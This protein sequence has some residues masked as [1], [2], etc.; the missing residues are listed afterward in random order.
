VLETWQ[1]TARFLIASQ[2]NE[3]HLAFF[4]ILMYYFQNGWVLPIFSFHITYL[5]EYR[6]PASQPAV[7]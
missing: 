2:T 1:T 7:L 3:R 6:I 5:T 4:C